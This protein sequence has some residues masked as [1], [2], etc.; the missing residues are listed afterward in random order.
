LSF[1][2]NCFMFQNANQTNSMKKSS[3]QN[4]YQF[5]SFIKIKRFKSC[6]KCKRA[7]AI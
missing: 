3:S 7:M 5:Y 2:F 4:E 6:T 1:N